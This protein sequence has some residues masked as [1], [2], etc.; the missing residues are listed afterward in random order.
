MV[1]RLL[2]IVSLGKL[3]RIGLSSATKPYVEDHH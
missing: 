2:R 1:K 3:T